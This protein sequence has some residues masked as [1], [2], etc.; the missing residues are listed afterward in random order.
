MKYLFKSYFTEIRLSY[1]TTIRRSCFTRS[2]I[3]RLFLTAVL[4]IATVNGVYAQIIEGTVRDGNSNEVVI[5]ASLSVKGQNKAT[6]TVT[7]VNGRFQLKVNSLPAVIEISFEG[8]KHKNSMSMNCLITLHSSS[9]KTL[10]CLMK[11][12]LSGMEHKKDMNSPV[13]SPPFTAKDYNKS[14]PR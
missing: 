11:S 14:H 7:D 1:F 5:G 6:G 4:A 12:S 13:L 2:C 10:D 9:Q 8:I 3:A